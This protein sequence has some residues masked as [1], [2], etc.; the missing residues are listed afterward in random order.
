MAS[1]RGLGSTRTSMV[2][3]F[4]YHGVTNFIPGARLLA[5]VLFYC[6]LGGD[7][8]FLLWPLIAALCYLCAPMLYN[9]K[10]NYK[11]MMES[12]SE[13]VYWVPPAP[14]PLHPPPLH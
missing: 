9:P 14:R 10:P 1:G 6:A 11:A 13:L 5:L 8:L 7:V 4:L 3:L 2:D 12:L